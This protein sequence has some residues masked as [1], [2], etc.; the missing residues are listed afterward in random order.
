MTDCLQPAAW[1]LLC[2]A[3]LILF[4]VLAGALGGEQGDRQILFVGP[5]WLAVTL[6]AAAIRMVDI[7][8]T[9][10]W[11][12]LFWF[13]VSSAFYFGFGSVAHFFFN[14]YTFARVTAFYFARDDE[15]SKINLINATAV[16]CVVFVTWVLC[17]VLP[18][19]RQTSEITGEPG[20]TFAVAMIFLGIG[21]G[22]KYI[23]IVPNALGALTFG[24]S[25]A[26]SFFVWLAP[27]GL[28][29]I[30][31][32]CLR[33][34]P[35][36]F[37][38][39]AALLA[40]DILLGLLLFSKSEVL[41]PLLMF[42]L[43][44]LLHRMSRMRLLAL[45]AVAL[46]TFSIVEP[47]VGYG[48][49][50][51]ALRHGELRAASLGERL[52]ILGRY[53]TDDS[54]SASNQEFQGS[55][56]RFSYI[57]SAAPAVAQYD[58]GQQGNSLEHAFYVFIPRALWPDKPV[59]DMGANYT[60][61]IDGTDT[62]ST[63]MGYFSEAYWNLGWLG[64]V[65]IMIALGGVLWT[66]S[67]YNLWCIGAGHWILLPVAFLGIWMGIRTDGVIVTDIISS[68][69]VMIIFHLIGTV[70]GIWIRGMLVGRQVFAG[71]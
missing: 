71:R 36:H 6:L 69:F 45:S 3:G 27:T 60:R 25:G 8:K 66:T 32:W 9:A 4:Y 31:L 39:A 61:M 12:S 19:R 17:R 28:F 30:T 63:W 49:Q 37:V 35:R 26:I 55:L 20:F 46:F 57:H 59:F 58:S 62:S 18:S 42:I 38:L 10:L 2:L 52:T 44:L 50:E 14:D 48:R 51:V 29:L 40:T 43:A 1:E 21:Y 53:F 54:T 5:I 34:S 68:V 16:F 13:R 11:S 22:I 7:D 24:F 67:R 23:I 70:A 65:L 56:V 47:L 41:L 33:H 64:V 15:M